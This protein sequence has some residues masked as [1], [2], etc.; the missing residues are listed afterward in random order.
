MGEPPV[1]MKEA[2]EALLVLKVREGEMKPEVVSSSGPKGLLR[3]ARKSTEV[4]W[5]TRE[6]LLSG[7]V[8]LTSAGSVIL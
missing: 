5:R 2:I 8:L 3:S 4:G 1:C 7:S 6:R